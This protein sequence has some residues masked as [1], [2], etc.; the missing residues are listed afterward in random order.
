MQ[1]LRNRLKKLEKWRKKYPPP[2]IFIEK[3]PGM[4]EEDVQALILKKAGGVR[5]EDQH[6]L[7]MDMTGENDKNA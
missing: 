7:I 1:S 5:R 4:T 6:V 2:V 3:K